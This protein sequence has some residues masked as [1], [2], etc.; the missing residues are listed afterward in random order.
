M[1][2]YLVIQSS[3][4]QPLPSPVTDELLL[5]N[6]LHL[7]PTP[8]FL[9]ELIITISVHHPNITGLTTTHPLQHQLKILINKTVTI[10]DQNISIEFATE[11]MAFCSDLI[12][13][14]MLRAGNIGYGDLAT[15]IVEGYDV[16]VAGGYEFLE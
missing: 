1:T 16:V 10:P 7:D 3:I 9:H 5:C 14:S 15:R 11:K 12:L 6:L 8:D 13:L 2:R 4:I